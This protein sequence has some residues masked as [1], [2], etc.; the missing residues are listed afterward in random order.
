MGVPDPWEGRRT[1]GYRVPG[2]RVRQQTPNAERRTPRTSANPESRVPNPDMSAKAQGPRPKAEVVLAA[3]GVITPEKRI[4]PI[5][6]ALAA[7]RAEAPH[8]RLRLVGEI[9][10][11]YALW[12]DVARTG[13]RDLI[14]VTG[15]V[16]DDQLAAELRAPMCACACAGRRHG[17]RRPRG[18][19]AW[20]PASRPSCPT[21]SAP[22]TCRPS[23]RAIGSSSTT[24]RTPR[25]CSSRRTLP[26]RRRLDRTGRR[27]GHA[28]PGAA[29]SRRRA[30][31]RRALGERAREWWEAHHTVARMQRDYLARL[32]WAAALPNPAWPADAPP[33]LHPDPASLARDLLAPFGV[34][35][36]ILGSADADRG[37]RV[38][39]RGSSET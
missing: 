38:S 26:R 30:P 15:Y 23:T 7:I 2:D 36:D 29:P 10:E 35:V 27:G 17:R 20:R 25:R 18:C 24:V 39:D 19:A 13:T 6:R 31:L 1:A 12:Q 28:P 14:E 16:D 11:H 34:E 22:S 32:E 33:H 37:S 8:V 4:L 9:G 21:S 3:F 5:L